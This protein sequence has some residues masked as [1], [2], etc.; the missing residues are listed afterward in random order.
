LTRV[1]FDSSFLMSV[2]NH[3]T[4]WFED[5]AEKVGKIEPVAL[6][7][8]LA[9]LERLASGQG[10]K[11]RT[12]RVAV[13]IAEEFTRAPCGSAGPDEEIMSAALMMKASVATADRDLARSLKAR[14]VTVFGLRSGRVTLL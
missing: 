3:P 13:K 2:A 10:R 14:R 8:V 7:C 1:I 4:T 12:A 6:E 5:L 11:S 9:E